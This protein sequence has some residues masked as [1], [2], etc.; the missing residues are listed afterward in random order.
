MT[1]LTQT[2][3]EIPCLGVDETEL[4]QSYRQNPWPIDLPAGMIQRPELMALNQA[5]FPQLHEKFG[6]RKDELERHGLAFTLYQ[7]GVTVFAKNMD[8]AFNNLARIESCARS[9]IYGQSIQ[10]NARAGAR[11]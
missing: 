10:A 5:V 8:E 4:K 3:G 7:H 2:L 1:S 6:G 11:V 9:Y